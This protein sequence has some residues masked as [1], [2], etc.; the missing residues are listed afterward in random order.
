MLTFKAINTLSVVQTCLH[1]HLAG[2]F[3]CIILYCK[4][5]PRHKKLQLQGTG[6][7]LKGLFDKTISKQI[8]GLI[9]PSMNF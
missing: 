5:G 8:G 7:K 6:E 3:G 1:L 9:R 2:L 4:D